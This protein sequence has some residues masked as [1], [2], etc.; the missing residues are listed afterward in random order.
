[1]CSVDRDGR[2]SARAQITAEWLGTDTGEI[3]RRRVS[4]ANRAGVRTF[5]G[6]F[7]GQDVDVALEAT[8]G[9]RFAV[10]EFAA[11]G[12]RVHLAEPAE[13]AA[14]RDQA[15]SK[16]DGADAKHLRELLGTAG[17][18]SPGSRPNTCL[19]CAPASGCGTRSS[20]SAANGNN[21]CSL[22]SITRR[23]RPSVASRRRVATL[24]RRTGSR[25]GRAGSR[26][27]PRLRSSTRS[28]SSSDR[29]TPT[30]VT[31]PSANPA[32]GR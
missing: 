21:E 29:S 30:C 4:P 16:T 24:V 14:L 13:A 27:P 6:R 10:A 5:A 8:T 9:W 19:R 11:V 20:T 12:A 22:S 32:A 3:A 18:R 25:A 2:R 7:A 1:V 28:T 17:Y 31:T 23:P 26:S 15:S